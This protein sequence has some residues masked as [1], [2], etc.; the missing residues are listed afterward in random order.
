MRAAIVG[1]LVLTA[2]LLA[3]SQSQAQRLFGP[4]SQPSKAPHFELDRSLD[5]GGPT[6][7]LD[8]L[9]RQSSNADLSIEE[10]RALQA[11]LKK[12]RKMVEI[13]QVFAFMT[14]G[15]I[16][17]ADVLGIINRN[18]LLLGEPDRNQLEPSIVAH[19]I[20]AGTAITSYLSAGLMAWTMPKA[21]RSSVA[22]RVKKANSG[23][24]HV[25]LS[26]V[27]GIAMGTVIATGILQA[28]AATGDAWDALV[29][30]HGAAGLTAASAVIAAGIVI[31]TL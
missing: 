30:I 13:H 4:A 29:G 31:G 15:S 24:A 26:V 16:V 1:A 8:A 2:T 11:Q 7:D 20:L 5:G 19:R 17:A 10:R 12:R 14:A 28:N 27:H 25:A 22:G 23:D 3:P 6:I 18:A 9:G 21:Y